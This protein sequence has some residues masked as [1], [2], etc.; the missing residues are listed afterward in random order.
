MVLRLKKLAARSGSSAAL[1]RFIGHILLSVLSGNTCVLP[2]LMQVSGASCTVLMIFFKLQRLRDFFA[3]SSDINM[4][5][6]WICTRDSTVF[7]NS[8]DPL[9]R[10]AKLLF[11]CVLYTSLKQIDQQ[12]SFCTF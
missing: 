6:K 8:T 10:V 9:L 11:I 3:N 12:V 2:T 7:N 4:R 1:H 5:H